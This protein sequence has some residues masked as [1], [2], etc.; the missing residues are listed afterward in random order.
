VY[1][2][3][4]GIKQEFIDTVFAQ[5]KQF[6][7][8]PEEE[9]A[10]LAWVSPRANRGYVAPGREKVSLSHDHDEISRLRKKSPDIKETIEIGKEYDCE[11]QNNWPVGMPK[12]RETMLDFYE[13][14]HVLHLEIL[15]SLAIGLRIPET[16]FDQYCNAKEHNLRLLRYPSCPKTVLDREGQERAGSHT[17]YGSI[18]LLFQDDKGGLQVLNNN[19]VYVNAK[20]IEGTIVVNAG[21]LLARWSNNIIRSTEHRVVSP[22]FTN[23]SDPDYPERY[24]IAYFCN[25]NPDAMIECLPGCWDESNPKKYEPIQCFEYLVSRLSATY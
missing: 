6:F 5:S 9:K 20:P 17:D 21:D 8:L 1:L 4:H 12:F 14:A 18:T 2:K 7:A 15:R 23:P 10:K 22:P 11:F 3:N 19:G 16:F 13:N 25:P 24:S